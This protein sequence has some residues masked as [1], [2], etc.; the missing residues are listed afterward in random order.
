MHLKSRTLSVLSKYASEKIVSLHSE[1]DELRAQKEVMKAKLKV[2]QEELHDSSPLGNTRDEAA[3]H[4]VGEA[5]HLLTEIERRI[6][7]ANLVL[8]D[9]RACLTH[10]AAVLSHPSDQLKRVTVN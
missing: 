2:L 5:R 7:Q 6:E 1:R 4:R 8:N 10:V 3:G 9:P